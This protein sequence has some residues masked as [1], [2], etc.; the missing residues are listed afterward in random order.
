LQSLI[1]H[2]SVG[3][4]CC[5]RVACE[6]V[7]FLLGNVNTRFLMAVHGSNYLLSQSLT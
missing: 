3:L 1:P 5:E 6:E 4:Q 2:P 7:E